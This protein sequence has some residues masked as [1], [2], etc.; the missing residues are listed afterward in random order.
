[1]RLPAPTVLRPSDRLPAMPEPLRGLVAIAEYGSKLEVDMAVAALI[2]TGIDATSSYDPASAS[3]ASFMASDR[4]FELL[5]REVDAEL[6]VE[7]L[8]EL[9][10]ALPDE[11][12][13]DR[14]PRRRS[15]KRQRLRRLVIA[16][17]LLWF[18]LPLLVMLIVSLGH[19]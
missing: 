1:M 7:R 16:G 5:V 14:G 2:D 18:A 8:Y 13:V 17:I 10:A 4:T 15:P 11:F 12:A 19:G 9:D 6:A 3:L